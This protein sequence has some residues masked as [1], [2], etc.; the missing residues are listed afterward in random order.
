MGVS[1]IPMRP[2]QYAK[3]FADDMAAMIRLGQDAHIA[4]AE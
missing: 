4:P 2:E 3:F 1:P